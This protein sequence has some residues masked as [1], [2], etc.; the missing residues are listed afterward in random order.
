MK[1]DACKKEVNKVKGL[2]L[3]PVGGLCE[4]CFEYIVLDESNH[5]TDY[6]DN[7]LEKGSDTNRN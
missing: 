3:V 5:T 6:E 4:S 7:V 2:S 1:C